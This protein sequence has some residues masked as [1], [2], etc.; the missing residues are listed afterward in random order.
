MGL[1][2]IK[3]GWE[4]WSELVTIDIH[5]LI[6]REK[7]IQEDRERQW[8]EYCLKEGLLDEDGNPPELTLA[9]LP[10]GPNDLRAIL[11]AVKHIP[12]AIGGL[13]QFAK[14]SKG[15]S[16]RAAIKK[17]QLP[18]QVKGK[19]RYVPPKNWHPSEPLPRGSRGGHMDKFGNEWTKGPSRTQGQPF[20]WD[21]Q[22]LDGTHWNVSL[23][24]KVTH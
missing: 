18:T 14:A 8:Y 4:W 3:N 11:R 10:L 23:D 17:A 2:A 5:A 24:G 1:C 12:K 20:E 9:E 7:K 21:V 6:E 22:R 13:K 19:V 15:L 16:K